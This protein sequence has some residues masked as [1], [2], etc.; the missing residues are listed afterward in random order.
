[1]ALLWLCSG[2]LRPSFI[3][4]EVL[5]SFGQVEPIN[6]QPVHHTLLDHQTAQSLQGRHCG[7]RTV[8]DKLIWG[9]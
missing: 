5:Q 6:G 4:A 2:G 3:L 7:E 8:R 9:K 1:M